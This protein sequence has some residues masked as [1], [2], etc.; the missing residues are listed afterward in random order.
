MPVV[1]NMMVRAGADFSEITT[2]SKKAAGSVQE[3]A[4]SVSKSFSTLKKVISVSAIVAV[5]TA[6]SK[7]AKAAA[8]A[9]DKQAEAEM[10]LARTMKNTMRASNGEIQSILDLAS[11]QQKLGVIGDEVT[12]AG[13]AQLSGYLHTS[14][15][16][17]QLVPLMDDMIAAQYGY[18]ASAESAASVAT[19][20]GKAMNGQASAL[21]RQGYVLTAAQEKLLKYGNEAQRAAVLTEVVSARVGGMNQAL[22]N[23][24]TG[25]MKQLANAMSDIKESFGR[26]VRTVGTVFLP[27]LNMVAKVLA[28]I[29]TLANKVA[30]TIAKVFGGQVA[31]KEWQYIPPGTTDVIDSAADATD[32]L[33]NSTIDAGE[34]AEEAQQ[35]MQ[36]A[37]F[38]TLHVLEEASK[39]SSNSGSGS[40]GNTGSGYTA[41]DLGGDAGIQEMTTAAE[42]SSETIGWLEDLLDKVKEKWEEFK[43]GIDFTKLKE[44]FGKLKDALQPLAE[45]IGK[46]L[47]WLWENVLKPLG[48]WTIN[49]LAPRL[50]EV[51]ANSF[52]LLRAVLELLAP[53][54]E[55][56]W[57]ILK[58]LAELAGLLICA[59]LDELSN[60]IKTL[61]GVIRG[62][63]SPLEAFQT[64]LNGLCTTPLADL[65]GKLEDLGPI[66][67]DMASKAFE[68][69]KAA[70]SGIQDWFRTNVRDPLV[71]FTDEIIDKVK[72]I[73]TQA[74]EGV[75]E[76]VNG[77]KSI[78]T[79]ALDGIRETGT[80]AWNAIK[81]F[82]S[83]AWTEIEEAWS[84]AVG[85]FEDNIFG[86]LSSSAQ[87][88][89]D[90]MKEAWA[91]ISDWFRSSVRDP[92]VKFTDEVIDK[93]KEIGSK[94]MEGVK[95]KVNEVKTQIN[96][97]LESVRQAGEK[98]WNA[99]KDFGSAAWGG[100]EE[101]WSRASTFFEDN[102]F[103]PL[104]ES[105]QRG[106]DRIKQI[107]NNVATAV[108]N[109]VQKIKDAIQ[110][111]RDLGSNLPSFSLSDTFTSVVNKIK[112][113]TIPGLA[114][115][116]VIPPNRQFTAV[117]GDQASG[118]NIETPERLLR[119]IMRQEMSAV[120]I[121]GS[122]GSAISS[123]V[124]EG[125]SPT[126]TRL[127]ESILEA[128]LDG[129][130]IVL[131]GYTV[132]RT[133]SR[134]MSMQQRAFG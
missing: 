103:A 54:F 75:M 21:T 58:W 127:L 13:A 45:D 128:V 120:G 51:L 26:A 38:D 9:Y 81:D 124:R 40:G 106:V 47:E 24:P 41:G 7:A 5:I 14:E 23:T 107:F 49:E 102:I 132:G 121:A 88:A 55:A 82:G 123:A 33:T 60:I 126:V 79:Q 1:K 11:A 93:V 100:I 110:K 68:A 104:V 86:P 8:E 98:T 17:Q 2:Q 6:I 117:L 112:S 109:A 15:A 125:S 80:K 91:G 63:I 3:M 52:D 90:S 22:A 92:L 31:G 18:D 77:V 101:T 48:Q 97:T 37:S 119:Q 64:L 34:A 76:K 69:V 74:M 111:V 118:F 70:W 85:F 62:E 27:V 46:G 25:R 20:L 114:E 131:D 30:Q 72:E 133:T 61:T 129:R 78:V 53:V 59:A 94:A 32:N 113:I 4:G 87:R 43:E 73:G 35:K 56:V 105:A 96:N 95:E 28:A 83:S 12:L 39:T 84:R 16:L 116:A 108:G 130:E 134:N 57:P 42:E 67:S 10:K 115:G 50:V 89:I 122:P 71:T 44:A 36:Q 19:I 99:I 65:M 29:A 66:I